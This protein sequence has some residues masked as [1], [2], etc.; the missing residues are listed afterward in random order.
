M[1][2]ETVTCERNKRDFTKIES[3]SP[4]EGLSHNTTV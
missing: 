3:G 1:R 4:K 2:K